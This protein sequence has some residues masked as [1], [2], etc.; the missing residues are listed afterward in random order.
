MEEQQ[1]QQKKPKQDSVLTDKE[2]FAEKPD[3]EKVAHMG[4]KPGGAAGQPQPSKS[5]E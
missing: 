3:Q 1:K 2:R 5:K 4:D